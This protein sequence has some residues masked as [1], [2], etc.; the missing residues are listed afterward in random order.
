MRSLFVLSIVGTGLASEV[1]QPS[2]QSNAKRG[3]DPADGWLDSCDGLSYFH[4]S[5]ITLM[6]NNDVNEKWTGYHNDDRAT[7]TFLDLN[8]CIG[9]DGGK[10]IAEVEGN[11]GNS[12]KFTDWKKTKEKVDGQKK[13]KKHMTIFAT[14]STG[15]PDSPDE[16]TSIDITDIVKNDNGF[17]K[18][19]NARGSL[20]DDLPKDVHDDWGL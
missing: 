11:F 4:N 12:C 6:C 20:Y 17:L 13:K 5:W 15:N 18:C 3:K 9:N 10:L 7:N 14:C 16:K 8:H 2:S 1:L 19:D